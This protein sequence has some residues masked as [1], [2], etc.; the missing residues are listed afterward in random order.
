VSNRLSV[1]ASAAF[2]LA[3]LSSGAQARPRT[4]MVET[5]PEVVRRVA[6]SGLRLLEEARRAPPCVLRLEIL[7]AHKTFPAFLPVRLVMRLS[8][9]GRHKLEGDFSLGQDGGFVFVC[10]AQG[11]GAFVTYTSERFLAAQRKSREGRRF[12]LQPAGA[13][14]EEIA[15]LYND[16][17]GDY[18][19]PRAGRYRIIAAGSFC[20][21]VGKQLPACCHLASREVS[22]EITNPSRSEARALGLYRG[23]EQAKVLQEESDDAD[24]IDELRTL[25]ARYPD[26]KYA[27][28]TREALLRLG[29]RGS[30]VRAAVG[31]KRNLFPNDQRLDVNVH[32]DF[33]R[34]T[35]L[36]GVLQSISRQA[37]VP[38]I[39][40]PRL[41][42]RRLALAPQDMSLREFM[43]RSAGVMGEWRAEGGGYR[44][45]FKH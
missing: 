20:P 14:S 12:L 18:A 36:A 31:I 9:T 27:A 35:P 17:T 40:D 3:I 26:S 1:C 8:N 34:P 24:A 7:P 42:S 4:A 11:S 33:P 25:L 37:H 10:V 13:V 44:L 28:L 32:L 19:F 45:V 2:S 43:Y 30:S 21:R 16:T 38:L 22:I 5:P 15:L 23:K 39:L 6:D 41:D 29:E